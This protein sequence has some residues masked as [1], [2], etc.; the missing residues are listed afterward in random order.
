MKT[1]ETLVDDIFSLFD[2]NTGHEVNETN[3]DKFA[4]NLKD[5]IRK[6]LGERDKN[7]PA[8]RFSSLGRPDRQVWYEAQGYAKE[9][10]QAKTY[11][12]FLYGDVIEELMLFLVKEAGHVVTDE[13]RTVECEGVLG[14]IDCIIDGTVVDVKSASPYGYQKFKQGTVIENDPFGYIAQLSG[15]ANVLTP[16]KEAAFLAFDKV[17]GDICVSKVSASIIA[18][19]PPAEKII[20]QKEILSEDTPPP[21]CYSDV[22]EGKSGNRKLDTGCSYCGFRNRCWPSVR[23][24]LYS[25]GPKYLTHVEELPRV[26]ELNNGC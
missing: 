25:T 20:H 8:L 13:Q 4:E 3:L 9:D 19:H 6:R 2:P 16:G 5:T 18:A 22:P 21:R 1:I 7:S 14:H 26:P 10:M 23:T 24:F 15:Y 11:Y 12:K 17:S